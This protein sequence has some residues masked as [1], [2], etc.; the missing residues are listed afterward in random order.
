MRLLGL[1]A[2]AAPSPLLVAAALAFT[3]CGGNEFV[4]AG[5]ASAG[6]QGS[7]AAVAPE[8][9][10]GGPFADFCA[11]LHDYYTRCQ[12]TRT[13]DQ[14]NLDNCTADAYDLSE[15][16]RSAFIACQPTITC[17]PGGTAWVHESCVSARLGVTVPTA[18]QSK[19]AQ[20]YCAMCPSATGGNCTS[21]TFFREGAIQATD[22][23]GFDALLYNDMIVQMI[24]RSCATTLACVLFRSC[25]DGIIGA[26]IP[27]DACK[28]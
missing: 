19:L 26:Q 13:C 28:D 23:P 27:P 7:D 22:A 5:D 4:L 15:A 17:N 24:D 3:A 20:D 10:T 2:A 8:A 21:T 25:E 6:S 1:S 12:F 11:S 9:E 14:R 18:Q 16:A